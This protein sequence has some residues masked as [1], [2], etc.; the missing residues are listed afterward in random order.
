MLT[1]GVCSI[2]WSIEVSWKSS[3]FW[4]VITLT[5]WGVSRGVST[6]RVAVAMLPGVYEPE[7]SVI[8]PS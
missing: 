1:P 7:P 3:I 6:S 4:R 2:T 5:D 8:S